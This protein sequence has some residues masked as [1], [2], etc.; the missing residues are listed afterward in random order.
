MTIIKKN[1]NL[2]HLTLFTRHYYILQPM[3]EETETNKMIP[4]LVIKTPLNL[5]NT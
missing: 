2:N 4:E 1:F 5:S 3:A